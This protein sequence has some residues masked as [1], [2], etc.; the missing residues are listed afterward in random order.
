MGGWMG[1][2]VCGDS[3][4][5]VM[6]VFR[7]TERVRNGLVGS[8][9]FVSLPLQTR[10]KRKKHPQSILIRMGFSRS[11]F[12]ARVGCKWF[13]NR[14]STRAFPFLQT[15]HRVYRHRHRHRRRRHHQ[16]GDHRLLWFAFGLPSATASAASCALPQHRLPPPGLPGTV[17]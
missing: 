1:A 5:K 10:Q 8:A 11:R 13:S 14:L 12:T 16:P 17:C 15:V 4:S 7:V 2:D 6:V 9:G 3:S